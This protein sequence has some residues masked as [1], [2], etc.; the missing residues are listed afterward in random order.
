MEVKVRK[1]D[2]E[3]KLPTRA[4]EGS[5]YFDVCTISDLIIVPGEKAV[6][7]T[8]LSFE[9]PFHWVLDIRPRSGLAS[10]G[11]IILNSPG[12]LDSDYRGELLISAFNL[13]GSPFIALKKG[14][15]VAQINVLPIPSIEFKEVEG[16]SET[17]R[18]EGSF[19]ST[20]D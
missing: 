16:L 1:L 17:E 6:V 5:A 11:L 4:T 15:R 9:L 10:K 20:G 18:G 3:A 2:K 8:G 14:D 12:T 13:A 19:G 7:H